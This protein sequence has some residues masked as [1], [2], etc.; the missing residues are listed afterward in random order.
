[1]VGVRGHRVNDS[2]GPR[3]GSRFTQCHGADGW[4][5]PPTV[6]STDVA[7]R[8]VVA[9]PVTDL[10]TRW[11]TPRPSRPTGQPAWA[12]ALLRRSR[13][14]VGAV[15][16]GAFRHVSA[17]CPHVARAPIVGLVAGVRRVNHR[18]MEIAPITL[19]TL[20][21][22]IAG[23]VGVTLGWWLGR[24]GER[25]RQ[26]REERKAAYVAFV[27]AAIRYRN[28][29]DDDE[30][31]G[32]QDERWSALAEVV[33]VAPPAIV[34]AAARQVSIGD[35]LLGTTMGSEER[36]ATFRELWENNLQF[37]RLARTDLGVG[38]ADPFEGLSPV[39]G[40]T[41]AFEAPS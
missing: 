39:V 31:R 5:A 9:L 32:R 33:L 41:I 36:L 35:R 3:S 8:A 6:V 27:H 18:R 14:G 21:V 38:I 7:R 37:T 11:V 20:L 23:P 1:M 28:A 30:R 10:A 17:R 4:R 29:H 15:T 34:Q 19:L 22:A 16:A 26:G 12:R 2:Q 25:E 13:P 24:R 40:E